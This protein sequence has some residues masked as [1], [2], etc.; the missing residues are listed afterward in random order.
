MIGSAV[1]IIGILDKQIFVL[2]NTKYSYVHVFTTFLPMIIQILFIGVVF[3][4]SKL[5]YESPA[6]VIFLYAPVFCLLNTRIIL[7][8]VSKSSFD[9]LKHFHLMLPMIFSVALFPLNDFLKINEMTLYTA[10]FT[11]NMAVYLVYISSIINQITEFLG[12]YCFSI[13]EKHG[14]FIEIN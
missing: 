13:R 8:T 12:I 6:L 7:A 11:M 3:S 2:R 1:L 14:E 10:I 4:Y 9:L 5:A